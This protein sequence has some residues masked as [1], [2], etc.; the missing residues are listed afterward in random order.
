MNKKCPIYLIGNVSFKDVISLPLTEIHFLQPSNLE[1]NNALNLDS[2]H[3]FSISDLENVIFILTSK[4]T[5]AALKNLHIP[6]HGKKAFVIGKMTRSAFL[7]EGGIPIAMPKEGYGA[8]LIQL[9][10]NNMSKSQKAI[11]FRARESFKNIAHELKCLGYCVGEVIVYESIVSQ[12][13]YKPPEPNAIII[14]GAPSSYHA[15]MQKFA[16]D[17]TYRAIAIG[18]STFEA[19]APHIQNQS[20]IAPSQSFHSCVQLARQYNSKFIFS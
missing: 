20:F 15:F 19:F 16:W 8:E 6:L 18:K 4:N 12:K 9:I 5:I 2:K 17:S 1:Y 14:F 3:D 7:K 11:Y 13:Y 10:Q